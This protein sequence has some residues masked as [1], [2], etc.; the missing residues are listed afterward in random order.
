MILPDVEK[1]LMRRISLCNRHAPPEHILSQVSSFDELELALNAFCLS[2][3]TLGS[4]SGR[5]GGTVGR[6]L[7]TLASRASIL[8]TFPSS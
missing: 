3:S 1:K 5:R 4:G 7:H 2:M 6:G 8:A